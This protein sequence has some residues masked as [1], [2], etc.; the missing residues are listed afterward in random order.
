[1]QQTDYFG[2]HRTDSNS[3]VLDNRHF[4]HRVHSTRN[5]MNETEADLVEDLERGKPIKLAS[6]ALSEDY[7]PAYYKTAVRYKAQRS[8]LL[9]SNKE[10]VY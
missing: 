3:R 2:L 7:Q 9:I 5:N 6:K 1:M 10:Y 4:T 8:Y